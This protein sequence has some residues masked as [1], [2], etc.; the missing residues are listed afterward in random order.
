MSRLLFEV[1]G[2]VRLVLLLL[3][4]VPCVPGL[5]FLLAGVA[6]DPRWHEPGLAT[7]DT[8][9]AARQAHG[10]YQAGIAVLGAGFLCGLAVV[11]QIV[12]RREED[13]GED[14]EE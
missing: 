6:C 12:R 8:L 7:P 13:D 3:V 9:R 11:W 4:A 14:P 10:L 5:T 2:Q 1:P